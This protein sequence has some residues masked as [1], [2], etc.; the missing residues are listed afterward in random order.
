MVEYELSL[1]RIDTGLL[2]AT[3]GYPSAL[4]IFAAL[5]PKIYRLKNFLAL[6]PLNLKL[7]A[8]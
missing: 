7:V 8:A 3:V 1:S 4:E 6:Q 5:R 2:V